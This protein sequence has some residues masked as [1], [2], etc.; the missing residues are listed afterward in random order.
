MNSINRINEE[1]DSVLFDLIDAAQHGNQRAFEKLVE[2]YD[3]L[4]HR[5]TKRYFSNIADEEDLIQVAT[6]AFWDAVKT[7]DFTGDFEAYAAKTIKLR[8]IDEIRKDNTEKSKFNTK[9]DSMDAPIEDDEGGESTV[10]D[11]VIAKGLSPE[12]EVLGKEGAR[13]LYRFMD[14]KL[15]EKERNVIKKFIAGKKIPEI[16]EEMD[17]KYKSVENTLMRVRNKM[18]DYIKSQRESKKIREGSEEGI[19]FSEDEKRALQSVLSKIDESKSLKES[20][21]YSEYTEDE[22][23]KE[24]DYLEGR[25]DDIHEDLREIPYDNRDDYLDE[26]DHIRDN[27]YRMEEYLNDEQY[28][29]MED[30]LTWI[31]QTKETKYVGNR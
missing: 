26:L 10:G 2:M 14:E 24:L 31:D 15:S 6:I 8:M 5:M 22:F 4:I 27:L 13:D 28:D 29:R 3:G 30:I 18:N 17:M 9:A 12:E 25:V 7:F 16:A 1:D 23:D 20:E 21:N 11:R 19:S